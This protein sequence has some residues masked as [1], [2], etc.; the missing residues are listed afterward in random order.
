MKALLLRNSNSTLTQKY[1]AVSSG[2]SSLINWLFDFQLMAE[3][4]QLG[5]GVENLPVQIVLDRLELLLLYITLFLDLLR[6]LSLLEIRDKG[7]VE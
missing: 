2:A 4:G 6:R 7:C 5:F 1:L 3:L